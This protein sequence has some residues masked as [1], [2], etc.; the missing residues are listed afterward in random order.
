MKSSFRWACLFILLSACKSSKKEEP[1][2][3]I[4]IVSLIKKQVAH[5]DTSLYSIKKVTIFDSLH[6]DTVY[7]QREDFNNAAKEFLEVPDL[8]V[9]KVA[10]RYREEPA[11]FDELLGRVIIT[12]SAINPAKEEYKTQEML[13]TPNI[14]SGD[15]VN[16]IIINRNYKEGDVAVTKNLLWQ[17]DKSFQIT[18]TRQKEGE[19]EKTVVTKVIWTE[20]KQE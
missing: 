17:M 4:S 6:S 16:T 7:I 8:S 5:I 11:R 2:N 18:T 13:V 15:R 10:K 12:Y 1:K 3:F 9:R 14:A 19:T 20:D